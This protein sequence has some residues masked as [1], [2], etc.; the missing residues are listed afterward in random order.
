MN[1]IDIAI[2][3]LIIYQIAIGLRKGM[4]RS[5]FDLAGILLV[6]VI[7]L[8][9]FGLVSEI[10]T[11]YVELSSGWLHSISF[12]GC[13]GI[14]LA[15]VK[16][17]VGI[18]TRPFHSNSP[19]LLSRLF[20]GVLGGVRGFI[21]SAVLLMLMVLIP[22]TD[23]ARH[24]FN[25]SSL[26]PGALPIIKGIIGSIPGSQPFMEKLKNKQDSMQRNKPDKI[27]GEGLPDY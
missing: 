12:L 25:Q 24:H 2:T 22:L 23:S 17:M 1:W 7:S 5:F 16:I 19:F 21:I 8:S 27:A 14:S 13:L 18:I 15:L 20:G 9:Q 3:T 4:I 26:A 10:L 11:R 6:A